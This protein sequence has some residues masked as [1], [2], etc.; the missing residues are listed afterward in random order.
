MMPTARTGVP[1]MR[2]GVPT[3]TT[4]GRITPMA[5]T[6]VPMMRMG[7]PTKTTGGLMTLTRPPTKPS[8]R[9]KMETGVGGQRP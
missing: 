4:G 8:A 9:P 7:V 5:R 3:K 6:G 2:M 1:M